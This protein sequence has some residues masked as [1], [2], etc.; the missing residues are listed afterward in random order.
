MK[1]RFVEN[2]FFFGLFGFVGYLIWQIVAPFFAALA[3]AAIIAVVWYP[4]YRKITNFLPRKNKTVGALVSVILIALTIFAPLF[5]LGYL[6]FLQIAA[7]YA[8]TAAGGTSEITDS[9]HSFQSLVSH[10]FPSLSFDLTNYVNEAAGWLVGHTGDIFASTASTVFL[11]FI[12]LI[13]LYYLLKDG[14]ACVAEAVRLSPLPDTQDAYILKK[15]S[16]SIRSVVLGTLS[17][18]LIQGIL[19][20][21]GFFVF[22]MSDPVLWGGVAAIGALIP[23]VG[24]SVVFIIAVIFLIMSQSYGVAVGLAIWGIF[25]VGLIDNFLGPYLMSRG[26]ELHPFLVLLSVLGGVALLGP[27]GLLLG[28]VTLS[29]FTVLLELYT[30]Y[31]RGEKKHVG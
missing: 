18:A 23:G 7:F 2:I 15:L 11:L 4:I 3:L 1:E 19:T 30:T 14:A 17:V 27:V 12:M 6:L 24:T 29:F 5:I 9:I 8:T 16:I 28:P 21:I 20:S 13:A 22:G 10:Y 31:V 26:A 25:A